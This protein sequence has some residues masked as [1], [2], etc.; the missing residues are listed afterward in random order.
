M[1]AR[2]RADESKNQ[3]TIVGYMPGVNSGEN[4]TLNGNWE[5][6]AR[7]GDQ[8]KVSAFEV[9]L[10]ATVEGIE[11]Y[12]KSGIIKG[13]GSK[14]ADRLIAHFA[15]RTLDIIEKAPQRLLEVEGVGPKSADRIVTAWQ[16][17]HGIRELMDFLFEYHISPAFGAK[18]LKHY[19]DRALSVVRNAPYQLFR[20]IPEFDFHNIDYLA[21]QMGIPRDDPSRIEA[22]IEY[23]VRLFVDEGNTF[24]PKSV[25]FESLRKRFGIEDSIADPVVEELILS[26]WITEE[27]DADENGHRVCLFPTYLYS[28]EKHIADRLRAMRTVP[29][30]PPDLKKDQIRA[31]LARK[32]AIVPS[33]EQLHILEKILTHRIAI[34]TGGPGTGKTT[35]VRAITMLLN[36]LGDTILLAAPT[37]RAAR[38][39]SEVTRRPAE[40]IHKM[41]RFNLS[42]GAFDKHQDDPLEA[43]TVIVDEV[44]MVDTLL[45]AQLVN[46][47]SVSSRLILVGDAFQL[48]SIGPGNVLSDMIRSTSIPCFELKTIFRQAHESPIV[49]AAHS[50]RNGNMPD[51]KP[52]DH[53]QDAS[54]FFFIEEEIPGNAVGTIVELCTKTF[55]ENL[56]LD[57]ISDVQVITPMHKGDVGTLNLNQVLQKKMNPGKKHQIKGGRFKRNDKVMHL[58]N[59]YQKEVFNGDIGTICDVDSEKSVLSVNYDGR[60]VAYGFDELDELSLAYA[61]SVHKSQGSEYPAVIV[62]LVTQHFPMLQRNLLYTA[63]TRGSHIVV[64]IGTKKALK[65]ALNNNKPEQR[66]SMLW[67]RLDGASYF[68]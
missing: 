30:Y 4:L 63:I 66:L 24:I 56:K 15:D 29:L 58:K 61:I 12:L 16:V 46:A 68:T 44:S 27:I 37:G 39:L 33:V 7:F 54:E 8:F 62:P 2:L 10:P 59:N 67:R 22:C 43:D 18:L 14:L 57:P 41:L 49:L 53:P 48:P 40:T 64:I 52:Y 47:V 13:I 11:K 17:H 6:H 65:I 34:I 45:M 25:L 42:T 36:D 21:G 38:R 20:D 60:I 23:Q 1:I 19:G 5:T 3:V 35:L 31:I 9:V 51:L 32:M 28:A 50:V 55:P 26:G